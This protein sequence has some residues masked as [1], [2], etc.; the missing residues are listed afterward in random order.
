[1]TTKEALAIHIEW[2]IAELKDYRYHA[3]RTS[4]PVYS[5]GNSL[6]AATKGSK[7]PPTHWTMDFEWQERKD[8]Y[9][10]GLGF[11]IWESK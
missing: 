7:K 10:N 9:L 8:P 1:M 3:G 2:D 4:A 5:I 6:M 11:K